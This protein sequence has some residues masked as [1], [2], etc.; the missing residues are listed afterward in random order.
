MQAAVMSAAE[1]LSTAEVFAALTSR[2]DKALGITR[3]GADLQA[4]PC[5]DY[6]DVLYYQGRM[7]PAFVWK[8]GEIV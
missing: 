3:S 1:K 2:A 8:D 6:R 7:K 4:Y 5:R